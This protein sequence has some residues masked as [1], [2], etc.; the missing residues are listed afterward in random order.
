MPRLLAVAVA[1]A[2]LFVSSSLSAQDLE[3]FAGVRL[4]I[5]APGARSTAMGGASEA[6][7]D[8]FGAATNPAS[9]A[10]QR[11]RTAA[12][13]AREVTSDTDFFTSG[14]I[15]SFT[16]ATYET[17][18]RG[19]SAASL[20]I[21]T[22]TATWA[23]FYDQPLDIE[24]NTDPIIMANRVANIIGVSI[25]DG[26]AVPLEECFDAPAAAGCEAIAYF[27]APAIA[28]AIGHLRLRRYGAAAARSFGNLD[29]G[30][31]AQYAE[32]DEQFGGFGAGQTAKGR[33]LTWNAG[34]QYALSQRVRFGASYRSG[35][36]WEGER[37]LPGILG[38]PLPVVASQF[39]TPSSYAAG[40]AMD[41]TENFT[42]AAD[43]VR[44]NYGEMI[45]RPSN[46][47]TDRPPEFGGPIYFEFPDVT[48][49]H[50][51]AEYRLSTRIPIALRAG[52]WREPKH[53]LQAGSDDLAFGSAI[54]AVMLPDQDENH[55]TAGIG[56]GDRI[57][58]DAAFDRS[59]NTSRASV[60]LATRF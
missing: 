51:G 42:I 12:V 7:S 41:V 50:A 4:R 13:E 3:S 32:L 38:E 52:W 25:R 18:S 21:P 27:S 29:V 31:S 53:R 6:L 47:F 8:A 36:E 24:V 58:F 2:A 9:L 55:L 56:I 26:R 10:K 35:A 57:R 59:E 30:A 54:N 33:Q 45:D 44:I 22:K 20:V 48:E 23:L 46:A 19:V 16:T 11:T 43:A 5:D 49:L 1:V 60:G 40:L 37:V 14:T 34:L 17:R 39:R 15:G 28:R